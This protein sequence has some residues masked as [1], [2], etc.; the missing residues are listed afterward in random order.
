MN[1]RP[2]CSRWAKLFATGNSEEHSL[3]D[4][5]ALEEHLLSCTTC[6]NAFGSYE[7]LRL[8]FRT[9]I[10][11]ERKP[12]LPA[13]LLALQTRIASQR[14]SEQRRDT[15]QTTTF[16]DEVLLNAIAD[17][18]E[19]ALGDL[20][21]RYSSL[22]YSLAY[23]IVADHQVAEDLLQDTFLTIWRR[24]SSY[25]PPAVTAQSWLIAILR[26]RS[27]D[28]LRHLGRSSLSEAWFAEVESEEYLSITSLE[29]HEIFWHT[30]KAEQ[31]H[32]A[33]FQLPLQ[34][35]VVLELA[36]FHSWKH[37]EIAEGIQT[38]IST[39]KARMRQGIHHLKWILKEMEPDEESSP[40]L[41]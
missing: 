34:E 29:P 38:P 11:R 14:V 40:L 15:A 3:Y 25:S 35:R 16:S 8:R 1:D 33:L 5:I 19:W 22:L 20:Y 6:A 36:F 2:P 28:Y 13:S 24:A 37:N 26:H 18:A 32:A 7:T 31:V 27:I 39:V 23:R 41:H 4:R 17:G 10:A 21:D 12:P 9:M 30:V